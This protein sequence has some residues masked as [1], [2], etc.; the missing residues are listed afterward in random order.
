MV[1]G[2]KLLTCLPAGLPPSSDVP[3]SPSFVHCIALSEQGAIA[4]STADGR[5]WIGR[6]GDKSIAPKNKRHRK[7]EG[8]REV[9]GSW[10]RVASG[11]VVSVCVESDVHQSSHPTSSHHHRDFA[12]SDNFVTCTLLG[13]LSQHE[14]GMGPTR[15]GMIWSRHVEQLEKVNYMRSNGKYVAVGG[16]SDGGKGLVEVYGE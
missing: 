10:V 11:P 1:R 6:G 9:G 3:L 13:L 12:G 7:W 15:T 8:L 5:V 4:A 14:V 2:D 16:F